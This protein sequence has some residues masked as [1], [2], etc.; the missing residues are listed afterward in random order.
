MICFEQTAN[1]FHFS[2]QAVANNNM[3]L[4]YFCHGFDSLLC[5]VEYIY[6]C[7]EVDNSYA[8]F[9]L[10]FIGNIPGEPGLASVY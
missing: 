9:S 2:L 4:H 3:K 10:G 7:G 5:M 1:C 8:T 6:M